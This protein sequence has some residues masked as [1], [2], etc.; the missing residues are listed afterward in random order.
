MSKTQIK[1]F[2]N[3]GFKNTALN[4]CVLG[5]SVALRQRCGTRHELFSLNRTSR[6]ASSN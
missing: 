5:H 6:F 2:I 4:L 1:L 3:A